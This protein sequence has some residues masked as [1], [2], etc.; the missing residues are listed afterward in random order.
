ME[1]FFLIANRGRFG[2]LEV[3]DRMAG[4]LRNA[5]AEA[6]IGA[7]VSGKDGR[8]TR[9]NDIPGDCDCVI[10]V[11]GDGTLIAA[12]RDTLGRALPILGINVGKLGFLAD[13]EVEDLEEA[14][15]ALTEGNYSIEERMMLSG[16]VHDEKGRLIG[17]GEALND[18]VLHR[19]GPLRI[20]EFKTWV[21]DN[22]LSP[23][24][25]DGI[26]VCTPT[27]ST[28]YSLSAGG[29]IIEP[30]SGMMC[31]TTI[32][33]HTLNNR[34]I[35]LSEREVVRLL[36]EDDST[37]VCFDARDSMPMKRGY[38][39]IIRKSPRCTKIMR[40][41]KESFLTVLSDKLR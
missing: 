10:V 3:A 13:V 38:S 17:S 21:N 23:F 14:V 24:Q 34:S 27:G 28:G 40:I 19:V 29:P 32:C 22:F 31:I 20:V 37:E 1:H 11:G 33:P 39:V 7:S 41:H 25:A 5:G 35:L 8:Y 2:A 9:E 26:I 30:S 6:V 36:P 16:E 18:I 15:T 12:A 4:L